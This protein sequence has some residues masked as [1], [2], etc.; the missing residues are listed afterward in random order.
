MLLENDACL[1]TC[2]LCYIYLNYIVMENKIGRECSIERRGMHTG[3]LVGKQE[4][5]RLLGRLRYGWEANTKMDL[6]E[7]DGMVWTRFM[8]FRR[9]T[10]GRLLRTS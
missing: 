1:L 2:T 7:L 3:F 5:K 9:G 4:R 10:R 8:W 6:K